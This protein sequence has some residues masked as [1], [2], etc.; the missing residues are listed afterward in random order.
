MIDAIGTIV[1]N[2][3]LLNVTLTVGQIYSLSVPSFN[4]QEIV[5]FQDQTKA[6]YPA[7]VG[8]AGAIT[9]GYIDTGLIVIEGV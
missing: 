6:V 3:V 4:Q 8:T 2:T 1:G 9:I 5:S 7:Y